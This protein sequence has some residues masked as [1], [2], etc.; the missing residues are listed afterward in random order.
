MDLVIGAEQKTRLV[1]E[2]LLPPIWIP[3]QMGRDALNP[4]VQHR[5]NFRDEMSLPG[6]I[7]V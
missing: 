4:A 6:L 3:D 1:E 7:S 2:D 5:I